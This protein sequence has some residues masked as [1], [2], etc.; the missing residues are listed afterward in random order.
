MKKSISLQGNSIGDEG[1]VAIAKATEETPGLDLYLYNVEVTQE[2]ISRVLELRATTRIKTMVL[3][4][5]W[6]SV[7]EEGK[8][9]LRSVMELETLPAL[10]VFAGSNSIQNMENIRTVL[11]EHQALG[12]KIRYLEVCGY[13]E[14]EGF[15]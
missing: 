10:R 6:D 9:A 4:S 13:R 14:D 5:S 15:F 12:R 11:T 8:E 3:G 7:C 2:G 1:V